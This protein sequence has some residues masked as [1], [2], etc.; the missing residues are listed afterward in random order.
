[1]E[2]QIEDLSE[3]IEINQENNK[4]LL[5]IKINKEI[6]TLTISNL[7]EINYFSYSRKFSLKEIKEINKVFMGLNSFKEFSEFLKGLIEIKKLLINK[8]EDNLYINFEVEYL[9]KKENIDIILYPEKINYE[10][11]IKELCKEINLIKEKIKNNNNDNIIKDLKNENGKLKNDI[12]NLKN[13]NLKLKEEIKKIKNILEPIYKKFQKK[14]S[15]IME[16]NEF[17]FIRK[18]IETKINKIKKIKKLYQ[19]TIDGEEPINFHSKC[20]NIPYTLI[21]FKSEGNRRFGG[22]ITQTWDSS[23]GFKNDEKAFLFSLDK[24]KIYKIKRYDRAIWCDKSFGPVF[25]RNSGGVFGNSHDICIYFHPL[26]KNHAH[27]YEFFPNSAYEFYGDKEALSECG[28]L[29]I[30]F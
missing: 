9:L 24:K 22:F 25:G 13:E 4:Y 1:M 21:I 30:I 2:A 8:K 5:L 11:V 14:N 15:V 6:M 10:S 23:S 28:S 20:D 16:E 12:E 26:T 17:D 27:T 18:E 19:A 29:Q 7:K 3:S